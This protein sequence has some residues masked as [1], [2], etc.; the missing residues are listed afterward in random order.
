MI[1]ESEDDIYAIEIKNTLRPSLRDISNLVEFSRGMKK[2]VKMYLFYSGDEY[3]SINDVKI[4]PVA[5][6]Y[7][8]Q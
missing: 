2:K 1:F 8:G 3:G 4:I 7:R 6:L 5:S